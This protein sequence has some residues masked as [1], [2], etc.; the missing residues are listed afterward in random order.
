MKKLILIIAILFCGSSLKSQEFY[1]FSWPYE[2]TGSVVVDSIVW[3]TVSVDSQNLGDKD[4]EHI[5]THSATWRAGGNA[6]CL[7]M[8]WGSHCSWDDSMRDR[9]CSQCTR[10]E[11]QREFWYEHRKKHIETDYEKLE[12]KLKDKAKK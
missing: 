2:N 12:K 6:G 1:D 8:H 3:K 5:W 9:I 10:K 11:T 7:V 4:C